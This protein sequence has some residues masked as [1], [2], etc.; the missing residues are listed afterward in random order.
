MML[1]PYLS[2]LPHLRNIF[3][4]ILFVVGWILFGCFSRQTTVKMPP[5]RL[6]YI[7]A[8]KGE[9]NNFRN[10]ALTLIDL[11]TS[12]VYKSTPLPKSLANSFARDPEGRIWI[13]FSGNMDRS[14]NRIQIYSAGGELITTFTTCRNPKAGIS[15]AS[16]HAFIA[17]VED[18]FSG[19]IDVI[20]LS[21]LEKE[22]SIEL[23]IDL[24]I[25][26][27]IAS[28]ANS[29]YVVVSGLTKGPAENTPYSAI[30]LINSDTL[31]IQAQSEPLE[32][33]DIWQILPFQDKFYML[34]AASYLR[35]RESANDIL[36]LHPSDTLKFDLLSLTR[37]P[38]WG[39]IEQ[40]VLYSFHNSTWN[41]TNNN[42]QRVVAR[43]D[44]Q[45]GKVD[46]WSLPD[47]WN[48]EGI[49]VVRGKII[50]SNWWPNDN[51]KDGLYTLDPETGSLNQVINVVGAE[52]MIVVP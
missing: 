28:A 44:L 16:G 9:Y 43:L 26:L 40:D 2:K 42:P 37:S 15:F 22:K 47:Q 41:S 45:S 3:L 38:V 52:K 19:T 36:V 11:D 1:Q 12:Q 18:G 35:P 34:N 29:H 32:A 46:K 30:T 27:L 33:V 25:Y 39:T 24:G 14:D 8:G 10:N 7:L 20:N 31:E 21:S 23:R 4:L 17:C 51:T 5:E 6:M 13:G 50:L 49:A 48:A